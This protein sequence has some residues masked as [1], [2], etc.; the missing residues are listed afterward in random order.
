MSS[1][2]PQTYLECSNRI[3]SLT[4]GFGLGDIQD[5]D[6]TRVPVPTGG[7]SHAGIVVPTAYRINAEK[8]LVRYPEQEANGEDV[9]IA[10][11]RL[12]RSERALNI[13]KELPEHAET[14][15]ESR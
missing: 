14:A 7:G 6:E 1:E 2:L 5:I 15:V 12:H 9:A 11:Y 3:P 13:A 10:K 4:R 8:A